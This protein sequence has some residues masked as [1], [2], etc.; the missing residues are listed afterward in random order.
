[1]TKIN[2]YFSF[3]FFFFTFIYTY[4]NILSRGLRDG[5][6][7]DRVG[8]IDGGLTVLA[9]VVVLGEQVVL[10]EAV[11]GADWRRERVSQGGDCNTD[12][13]CL[14]KFAAR[15]VGVGEEARL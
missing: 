1:M 9:E 4:F 6:A 11:E 12:G 8:C 2:E 13:L 3:F 14:Q 15:G 7:D 5:G 10:Q